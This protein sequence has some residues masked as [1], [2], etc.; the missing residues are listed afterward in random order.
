[1]KRRRPPP[2]WACDQL[3]YEK[4]LTDS[5]I[6]NPLACSVVSGLMATYRTAPE[7][8]IAPPK[9]LD[10]GTDLGRKVVSCSTGG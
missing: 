3:P 4:L 1:M 6:G 10:F 5:F 7:T 2:N 9:D 8:Q